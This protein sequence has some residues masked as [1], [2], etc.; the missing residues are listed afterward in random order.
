DY[1]IQHLSA[2]YQQL[3]QAHGVDSQTQADELKRTRQTL[4]D[5]LSE[6]DNSIA[7]TALLGLSH[8]SQQRFDGFDQAKISD[9]AL[10]LASQNGN[11]LTR[12][13]ALQVCATLNAKDS[14]SVVLGAAQAGET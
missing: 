7:G 1:A 6:T 9:K 14:L 8:L 2:F 5:A 10:E 4:W 11:E 3:A 12:I 13:T